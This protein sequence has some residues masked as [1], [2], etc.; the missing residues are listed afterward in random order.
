MW[1]HGDEHGRERAFSHQRT[2][3]ATSAAMVGV[4]LT[5]IGLI[6]VVERLSSVRTLSRVLLGVDSLVFLVATFLS[7][8]AMRATVRDRTSRLHAAAEAAVLLGLIGVVLV[9]LILVFTLI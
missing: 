5:A 4:C 7:F 3:F 1:L 2:L 9:C 6:L 8:L